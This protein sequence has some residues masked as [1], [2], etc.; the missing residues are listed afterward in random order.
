MIDKLE[1]FLALAR[2]RH[3]GRAAEACG[4]SQPSLSAGIKQLEESLGVLLVQRGSRFVGLT[5]EGEHVL[6]WAQRI[7][8]DSRAMRA[9]VRDLRRGLSGHLRLAAVPTALP[10][11]AR[12]TTPYHARH[13]EV[14]FTVL[15]RTSE[16]ILA[17]LEGLEI[18]A[19]L[20]YAD[21]ERLGRVRMQVL[22]PERYCLVTAAAGFAG[23]TEVAWSEVAATPLCLLTPDMQNRRILDRLLRAAGAEPR[24]TLQSNSMLSLLAHVRGGGW[25]SVMAEAVADLLGPACGLRVIPIVGGTAHPTLGL[26]YPQ[27]DPL[28]PVTA[29][30][31]AEAGLLA[32]VLAR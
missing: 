11:V 29:A 18:D 22:A 24:V 25:A 5:P 3:F 2:E 7:V 16:E 4:I 12:L 14:E 10:L 31:V 26:V 9:E 17:L 1:F 30:L 6:Q 13:P 15:S 28:T 20:T 21:G 8:A 32:G 23:R 27:R 19:G